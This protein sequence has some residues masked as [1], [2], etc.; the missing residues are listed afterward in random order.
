MNNVNEPRQ[1]KK[2]TVKHIIIG[3]LVLLVLM[4]LASNEAAD[5]QG[6]WP[7]SRAADNAGTMAHKEYLEEVMHVDRVGLILVKNVEEEARTKGVPFQQ[8][9]DEYGKLADTERYYRAKYR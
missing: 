2:L 3:V 8:I 5:K 9:A 7:D 6:H 1:P 4:V